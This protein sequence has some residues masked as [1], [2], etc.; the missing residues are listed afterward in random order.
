MNVDKRF[1]GL[2][3]LQSNDFDGKVVFFFCP[4]EFWQLCA[5]NTWIR[6][7]ESWKLEISA[8]RD[9]SAKHSHGQKKR[10]CTCRHA[11]NSSTAIPTA[12][13]SYNM[14]QSRH[15][16]D[17]SAKRS[18]E[19]IAVVDRG[20]WTWMRAVNRQPWFPRGRLV[21]T[22]MNASEIHK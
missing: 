9:G 3:R 21:E 17:G 22:E 10:I 7:S 5:P 18:P 15:S 12:F 4:L 14:C 1:T 20:L 8:N 11:L 19:S 6:S 16:R 2:Q 13:N